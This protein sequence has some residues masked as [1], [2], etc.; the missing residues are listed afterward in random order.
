LGPETPRILIKRDDLTGLGAGGNKGRK[1]EYLVSDAK[2]KGSDML[3]T[4]G[5]A[6]S[7]HALQ[8]AAA[9][10]KMGFDIT[11][12]LYGPEAS[13]RQVRGNLVLHRYLQTEILWVSPQGEETKGEA[14]RRGLQEAFDQKKSL[15]RNPYLVPSG[16]STPVGAL[17]YRNAVS[18]LAEQMR[19]LDSINAMYFASGSG[20]T[21]AGLILGAQT[22]GWSGSIIGVEVD[23]LS[24]NWPAIGPTFK[25][26]IDAI[27]EEAA[28]DLGLPL[29]GRPET[30]LCK[31]FAGPEYGKPTPAAIEA[32]ELVAQTQGLFLDPVY[33]GKAMSALI[34]HIREGRYRRTDT[35]LFWHTGGL[36]GLLA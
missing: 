3:V 21:H 12:V 22:E 29:S 17:G 6:Q 1:L 33:T 30:T 8:T 32:I 2:E 4:C 15:G 31:D 19:G 13:D 16:G 36:P 11:C 23:P 5:A 26:K 14:L 24:V 9:A 35:V 25:D 7:N 27:V 18:E 28:Q 20:G 34:G 10:R